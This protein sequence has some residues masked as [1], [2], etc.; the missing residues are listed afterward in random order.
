MSG[1]GGKPRPAASGAAAASGA[2]RRTLVK[3]C[4]LTRLEDAKWAL[5]CGADWLGFIVRTD[6]P[7]RIE[8]DRVAAIVDEL[9]GSVKGARWQAV[10]VMAGAGA[11]EAL[12]LAQRC[13][14]HRVQL[15]GSD[16]ARWP[17]EF[18][19]PCAFAVGVTPEGVLLADEPP[20]RHLLMLDTSVAGHEGGTGRT[21]PWAV[22][23]SIAERRDVLLAGG[24]HAENVAE[25]IHTLRP[26]G[27]DAA[28]RLESRPGV[29]DPERVRRFVEAVR[30]CETTA[31]P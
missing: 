3:I 10:A 19:L 5:E 29:K 25:A 30:L 12:A 26:F 11:N 14:A 28:S 17:A 18:P 1:P 13:H 20:A 21:W 2:S 31:T 23:H 22:A 16:A 9:A 7:R 15:H 24:L 8:P 4:G 6:G 27:V